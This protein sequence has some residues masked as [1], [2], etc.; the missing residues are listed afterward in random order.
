MPFYWALFPGTLKPRIIHLAFSVWVGCCTASSVGCL[1]FTQLVIRRRVHPIQATLPCSGL[2]SWSTIINKRVWTYKINCMFMHL[3][4]VIRQ[5]HFN[6]IY[7]CNF[8]EGYKAPNSLTKDVQD[9]Y[10]ENYKNY[11][12]KSFG[13]FSLLSS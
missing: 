11:W 3:E 13:R 10:T 8:M 9:F 1:D 4:K 6:L 5:C 12:I 2:K 7:I